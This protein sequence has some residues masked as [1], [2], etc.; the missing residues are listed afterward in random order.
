[1][2]KKWGKWAKDM[3]NKEN[4]D[5]KKYLGIVHRNQEDDTVI[6]KT[7]TDSGG[8][9]E[10]NKK[11]HEN[12]RQ[13]REMEEMKK[14]LQANLIEKLTRSEELEDEEIMAKG[15]TLEFKF[16]SINFGNKEDLFF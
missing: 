14:A 6:F 8:G 1:M 9:S 13:K 4:Q 12:S 7:E 5:Q 11:L 16:A 2:L 15:E 10:E 3:L